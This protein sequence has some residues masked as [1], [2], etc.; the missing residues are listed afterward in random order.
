MQ[1]LVRDYCKF[2]QRPMPGRDWSFV[3][4]FALFRMAVIFQG[5]GSRAAKGQ[6]SNPMA[7]FYGLRNLFFFLLFYFMTS[8]PGQ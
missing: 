7:A 4:A 6:A 2:A 3:I 1:D 5:I 8:P